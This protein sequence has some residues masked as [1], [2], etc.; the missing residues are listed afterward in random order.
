MNA[1]PVG[2][3]ATVKGY[4]VHNPFTERLRELGLTV[5]TRFT[6]TRRAPFNGPV[7][8]RYGCSRLVL[9]ADEAA[10]IDVEHAA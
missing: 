2:V 4:M 3:T 6:I 7:E 10:L 5:G 8:V 1:V 9:R